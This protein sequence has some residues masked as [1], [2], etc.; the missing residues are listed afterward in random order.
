[1]SAS[2]PEGQNGGPPGEICLLPRAWDSDGT[3]DP[4][5]PP[6]AVAV[7]WGWAQAAATVRDALVAADAA[8]AT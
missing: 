5:V 7:F 3:I 2:T 8:L 6:Y 1:M 4:S